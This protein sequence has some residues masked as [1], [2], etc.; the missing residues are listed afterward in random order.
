MQDHK[1]K[2][3][4]PASRARVIPQPGICWSVVRTNWPLHRRA[5]FRVP[6]DSALFLILRTERNAFS[7]MRRYLNSNITSK[8]SSAGKIIHFI[9]AIFSVA[10]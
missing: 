9:A 1:Q 10:K 3:R 4:I 2:D 6:K 5:V 7:A 8:T